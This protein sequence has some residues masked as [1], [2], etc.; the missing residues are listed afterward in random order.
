MTSN[1][2]VEAIE[3]ALSSPSNQGSLC[4][5][6]QSFVGRGLV[7]I[8][9]GLFFI[10]YP[11]STW[12]LFS[13]VFGTFCLLDSVSLLIAVVAVMLSRQDDVPDGKCPLALAL[14]IGCVCSAS[15]GWIAIVF[16]PATAEAMLLLLALW[17]TVNGSAMAWTAFILADCC[18]GV[19]GFLYLSTGISFLCDLGGNIGFF[20]LWIGLCLVMF[21][22]QVIFFGVSL[23]R[24]SGRGG[25]TPLEE[26][27]ASLTA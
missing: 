8:G 3:E 24:A 9:I 22:F 6:W 19:I 21:G 20:I 13:V 27:A 2:E 12:T 5:V 17:M 23:K 1:S 10:F 7:L 15:I 25:Y 26:A 11:A 4:R 16:P 14:L 18:T